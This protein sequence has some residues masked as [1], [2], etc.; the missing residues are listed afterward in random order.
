MRLY[1]NEVGPRVLCDPA[2][3]CIRHPGRIYERPADVL[4]DTSLTLAE[5]RAILSAWAS[6]A[7]AVESAPPLRHAPF[8]ARPVTFDEVM[9][10]L[11]ALDRRQAPALSV[12]PVKKAKTFKKASS[13]RH[14]R[15]SAIER[16]IG[17][18]SSRPITTGGVT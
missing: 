17:A 4:V 12:D 14:H 1:K 18:T 9:D 3:D 15:P 5:Q 13:H 8:A 2:V 6:D 10:A 7:C 11:V 16:N